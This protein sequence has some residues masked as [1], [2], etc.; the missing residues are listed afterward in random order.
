MRLLPVTSETR[1]SLFP[2]KYFKLL[3]KFTPLSSLSI[4]NLQTLTLVMRKLST[5]IRIMYAQGGHCHKEDQLE[6]GSNPESLSL[7]LQGDN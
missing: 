5:Q 2:D 3:S 4:W 6:V 7:K 1:T